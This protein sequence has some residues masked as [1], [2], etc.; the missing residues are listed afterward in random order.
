M[1]EY[2]LIPAMQRVD[3]VVT[4]LDTIYPIMGVRTHLLDGSKLKFRI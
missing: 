3:M 1:S 4:S 2:I